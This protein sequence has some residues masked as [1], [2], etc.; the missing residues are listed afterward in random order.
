[1]DL[2]SAYRQL[3]IADESLQHSYLSVYDPSSGSAKLFQQVALPFGSR[4][5][6]NAFIRCATFL[7]WIAARV[8]ILPLTCY[9]DDFVAFSMPNLCNNSQ[10]TLCLMLDILGW[11]FDREGPKSDAFSG[12]VSALGYSL[13]WRTRLKGFSKFAIQPSELK[14]LL[15]CWKHFCEMES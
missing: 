2:A 15:C 10:A 1:M 12:I 14:T 5:A 3:A 4:S 6:V 7:Q 13:T 11:Q 9:F 8:F